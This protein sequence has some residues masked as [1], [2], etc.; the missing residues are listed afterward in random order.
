MTG[1]SAGLPEDVSD[2]AVLSDVDVR[3]GDNPAL[4]RQAAI[5]ALGRRAIAPPDLSLLMQDA[6]FLAAQTIGTSHFGV[7]EFAP[8]SSSLTLRLGRTDARDDSDNLKEFELDA[9]PAISISGYAL[10]QSESVTVT[11]L[12]DDDRLC[13]AW[14]QRSGVRSAIVCPLRHSGDSF[15]TLGVYHTVPC[16]FDKSDELFFQ[17]IAH[18][19][20]VTLARQRA[21]Q[22]LAE[23]RQFTTAVL[24]RIDTPVLM[25][26]REGRIEN[27]NAAFSEFTG[28]TLGD[29]KG[30]AFSSICCL[31][32]DT[33]SIQRAIVRLRKGE[34]PVRLENFF[35]TK[36]G[37]RCRVA[38]SL[39]TLDP[40]LNE[41]SLFVA[42]G[43][44]VTRQHDTLRRLDV[45]KARAAQAEKSLKHLKREIQGRELAFDRTGKI[46]PTK[47]ASERRR[48]P[49]H[50]YPYVQYIAPVVNDELPTQEAFRRVRCRDISATGFS[51]Y[52][53]EPPAYERIVIAFG[54]EPKII[55]MIAEIVHATPFTHKGQ[56]VFLVGCRYV[57][58]ATYPPRS[59]G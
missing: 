21:E 40:E 29:V 26:S 8:G 17:S 11:N 1:E 13:D 20:T 36:E 47:L 45:A 42:T 57:D 33:T 37:E 25:L 16:Q 39:C 46:V 32:E 7:V 43:V 58:R 19:M 35:L 28:F 18:L 49:R 34:S 10:T 4:S 14:L 56:R 55:Y 59:Q 2:V 24:K 23:T 6:A 53:K 44:D 15:G 50:P 12:D 30:K 52:C 41:R 5:V 3:T 48:Q 22:E 54:A 51:I 9:D 38:W 27:T 31:P